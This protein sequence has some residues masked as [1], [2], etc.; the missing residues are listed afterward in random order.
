[1]GSVEWKQLLQGQSSYWIAS[2]DFDMTVPIPFGYRFKVNHKRK[3]NHYSMSSVDVYGNIYGIGYML[4]GE[5]LIIT[6]DKTVIVRPGTVQFMH[7]NLYHRTTYLSEGLYENI[8]IKFTEAVAE[9]IISV[10]GRE[11][12]ER[13]F[14]QISVTLTP[15]ARGQIL[16]IVDSIE[17][18]WNHYDNYSDAIIESLTIQFFVAALRGQSV[19]PTLDTILK[20]KQ[21]PLKNA[22][23]YIQCS[24]ASDPSL[25]QTADAVHISAA[26][27]SRLF[28]TELDTSYSRFLT[29]I[30]LTHAM[31]LLL[32]TRLPISEIAGLCGYQNSNYFCDAFKKVIGLSPLQ[33]RKRVHDA[34]N[35]QGMFFERFMLLCKSNNSFIG[36]P[37]KYF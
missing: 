23:H 35:L 11:A 18:E 31:Q 27:L 28:R 21:L 5:R 37:S 6:P 7:K 22:L 12:F 32:S 17:Y 19:S 14:E 15:E 24:Y 26:Y 16:S 4:S 34:V 36:H 10:I 2:G 8:D 30:K 13:L 33:Y 9:R 20:E 25:K 1:M 29:E 3:D